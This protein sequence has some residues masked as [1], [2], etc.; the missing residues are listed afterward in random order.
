MPKNTTV[1]CRSSRANSSGQNT[2]VEYR[3]N[4]AGAAALLC[5]ELGR[6]QRYPYRSSQYLKRACHLGMVQ[7]HMIQ[8]PSR[9][10]SKQ[11]WVWP[12]PPREIAWESN[13]CCLLHLE[14]KISNKLHRHTDTVMKIAAR[15]S[16]LTGIGS[17]K[18]GNINNFFSMRHPCTY[19]HVCSL[20]L[21]L[22]IS[23]LEPV[24]L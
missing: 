19:Q 9:V 7:R 22:R 14:R 21:Y 11:V 3:C 20:L 8:P 17:V 24:Y 1:G 2:P 4:H 23:V 18:A 16:F 12:V 6:I 5:G 15:P 13:G 10:G